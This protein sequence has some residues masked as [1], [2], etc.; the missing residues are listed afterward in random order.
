MSFASDTQTKFNNIVD[1]YG[2]TVTIIPI[3]T[4]INKVGYKEVTRGSPK[5]YKGI[6]S[7][8]SFI[9]KEF[10]PEGDLL[11]S[12][13]NIYI[14]SDTTLKNNND[15]LYYV[16]FD[17][18][19]YKINDIYHIKVQDTNVATRLSLVRNSGA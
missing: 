5:K 11:Y 15:D 9:L 14:K 1:V 19:E 4:V 18:V 16:V 7:R 6:T 3:T 2:N 8:F 10:E 12:D 13:L 17:G